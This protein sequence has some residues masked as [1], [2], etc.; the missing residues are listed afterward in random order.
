VTLRLPVSTRRRRLEARL[1]LAKR[2]PHAALMVLEHCEPATPRERV[3]VLMLRARG[4]VDLRSSKAEASL[5][6]AVEAARLHDFTFA[7]AEELYPLAPRLGA[8]L[9]SAPLDDFARTVLDL[10]Q[11]VVP[12]AETTGQ[13]ALVDPLTDRELVV[14]RYLASRLTT[15]EI[16]SELY[17]SVN[18]VR[19]HTKAVYR[20]LGVG[21][22]QDAIAE[23]RR[24]GIR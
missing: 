23:A 1:H 3:D 21:S 2:G 16:G 17:V 10:L 13:V 14:L 15:S 4:E 7:I 12:L 18:T 11:R 22:R 24:L 9:H 19:T 8:L 20:K 5:A 6:A